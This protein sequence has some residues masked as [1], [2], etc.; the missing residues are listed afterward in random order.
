[1]WSTAQ[2]GRLPKRSGFDG[3]SRRGQLSRPPCVFAAL[4]LTLIAAG[5][6]AAATAPDDIRFNRDIRPILSDNCFRCHGPDRNARMMD[7]RLDRRESAVEKG[8]IV[9]GD[10]AASKLV[11]RIR[12]TDE[13]RRM[14]PVYSDKKL[15][16]E[17]KALLTRWIA[18]GAEY[19]P[20]WAYI[21]PEKAASPGG[22]AAIDFFVERRLK[23]RGLAAL[24]EADRRTLIRRLSFDLTG[25]PPTPDE[26]A[27]F[28]N[29]RDPRAYE[30]VLDRLLASPAFGERM[31][32]NWLDLVRYADSVG[33]HSD[34]PINVYPYRDYV[35][36][37]FNQNMPF[38]QFTREQL[39]GDLL[40]NPTD[41][42]LVAT[43]FNRLNRMTNEGGSQAKEYL[44][45]YAAD[46]VRTVSITWLGSTMGCSECHDHKFDPFLQKEFYQMGAFFSDIEEKGVYSSQA[47]WG[48]SVRVLPDAAKQREA[49]IERQLAELQKAGE[50]KLVASQPHLAEFAGYLREQ[51]ES[52]RPLAPA[53]VWDD[54]SEPDISGCKDLELRVTADQVV[55]AAVTGE[56][57]PGQAVYKVEIPAA[58]GK[59]TA[60]RLE[61]LLADKFERFLLSKFEVEVLGRGK[62]PQPVKIAAA[63]PDREEPD[64]MLR[65]TLDDNY[66]TVWGGDLCLD[67]QRQAVFVFDQPLEMRAGERLLVTMTFN[68]PSGRTML[69]RFRLSATESA[70]PGVAPMGTLRDAVLVTKGW[71]EA[72]RNAVSEAFEQTTA[73]NANWKE[74]RRLERRKKALLDFADECLITRVAAEPRV[75][76]VLGRGDWMDE[77]GEIVEPGMPHFLAPTPAADRRLTRLDLANWLVSRDNPLTARV[78]VNRL[79]DLYFGRGLSKVLDDLG[80]QGE[81]PVEQDLLD[82]LAVDFMQSGWDVKHTIRTILLSETYR[83]SSEPSAELLEKDPYNRLY[84]R[85]AMMRLDAEFVRDNALAVSGLLN[86]RIGGPSVNP[87]QPEGYYGELNFPKRAYKPDLNEDQFRRGVYT[88]WQRTFLHPSLMAFDA[89]S[90]EECTADRPVSNTPLQSLA[91]LNDPTY[92]EAARAFGVRILQAGTADDSARLD[93]A[94]RQAFSRDPAANEREVLLAFLGRQRDRFRAEPEAAAK[95]LSVGIWEAPQKLDP[96]ELAA[97]TSVSRALFNKHEFIT[98]Y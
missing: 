67:I 9:P 27:A 90:R 89:P 76:R 71:T 19:E 53:R 24:G 25:L 68:G 14:P 42:Q 15:T 21:A 69:G 96:V 95:L 32:V 97:W 70:F 72:Q 74:I 34:V 30:K 17:Q 51:M 16:D 40:P 60:V 6:A 81:T 63:V 23:E 26:V 84:G 73:G 78:F 82:W 33:F 10:P 56:K 7:L 2:L 91:L 5:H 18:Q 43:A 12:A 88:H 62:R 1:M 49:G 79:W 39:A 45:K 48:P 86:R 11:E 77:S 41:Q 55:E 93:F 20:H 52:W 58:A 22:P 61:A 85:Q 50:G 54:C 47:N 98:R 66:H 64:A 94:F 3:L 4:L 46:R 13:V 92:V 31:A 87:Y 8:A 44:V 83:R 37:A 28:I 57:K 65:D 29:D 35:I 36:R 75:V 59:I 80:S 38:D